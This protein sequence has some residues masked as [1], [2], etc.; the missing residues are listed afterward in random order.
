MA[1]AGWKWKHRSKVSGFGLENFLEIKN[2][3][4]RCILVVWYFIRYGRGK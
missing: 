4:W 1:D 2:G 3:L